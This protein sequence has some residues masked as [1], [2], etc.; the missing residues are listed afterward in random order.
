MGTAAALLLATASL[1]CSEEDG[2]GRPSS[3]GSGGTGATADSGGA[4]G[5]AG[6]AGNAGSAGSGGTAG[7]GGNAGSGGTAGAPSYP[8]PLTVPG[9]IGLMKTN[10]ATLP[11]APNASWSQGGIVVMGADLR[12]DVTPNWWNSN[13]RYLGEWP[14]I[15]PWFVMWNGP[16]HVAGL[17]TRI[18]VKQFELFTLDA[19]GKWTK[20]STSSIGGSAFARNLIDPAGQADMRDEPDGSLS[21][22]L[23]PSGDVFHGWAG[24]IQ[25]NV[26]GLRGIH[27]RCQARLILH[28]EKGSDDR[29]SAEYLLSV[30]SDAYVY[31]G[32]QVSD[33]VP[34]NYNPGLGASKFTHVSNDWAYVGWVNLASTN[35]V[36]TDYYSPPKAW[37][38]MSDAELTANPPPLN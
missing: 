8:L 36:S 27:V 26:A 10:D 4:S 23:D 30:G 13:N 20:H 34:A 29:A 15:T 7:S 22:R 16:K 14:W 24:Q 5:S 38:T 2:A 11:G 19:Q 32:Q 33:F 37:I 9:L 25:V 35:T 28:D 1:A 3:G 21:V 6:S 31:Q 12:G 18:A 17:N